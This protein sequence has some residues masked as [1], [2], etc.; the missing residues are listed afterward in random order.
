MS[1]SPIRIVTILISIQ[2]F[3]HEFINGL[4]A[5]YEVSTS[6][7]T[8]RI[9]TYIQAKTKQGNKYHLGNFI[10]NCFNLKTGWILFC[11]M[12]LLKRTMKITFFLLIESYII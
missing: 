6:E 4:K 7:E 12:L 11:I 10:R 5:K 9:N 2:F 1:L 8:N 3:I